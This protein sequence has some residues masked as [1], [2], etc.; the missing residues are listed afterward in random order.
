MWIKNKM[1]NR[2]LF[3]HFSFKEKVAKNGEAPSLAPVSKMRKS[4]K[5]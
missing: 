5:E 1:K 3:F 2:C 4:K